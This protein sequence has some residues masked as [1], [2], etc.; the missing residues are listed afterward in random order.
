MLDD[1][2]LAVLESAR[3]GRLATVDA[4]GRPHV[5][6][7]CFALVDAEAGPMLVT[8]IDEKSK[9]ADPESLR[10]VRNVRANPRVAVVVDHYTEEWD[11][12]GWLQLRGTAR[13]LVPSADGHAAAIEGLRARYDQYADHALEER[14]VIAI[15]PGSAR[16]W[17]DLGALT[18]G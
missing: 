16:S 17:G 9:S 2:A 6:P 14:P 12:L 15:E 18:E 10:R 3:V 7:I 11:R 4:E 8:P 5:V 1:E 13:V